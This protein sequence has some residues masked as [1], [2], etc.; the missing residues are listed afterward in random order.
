MGSLLGLG[1]GKGDG[2]ELGVN[3]AFVLRP[4]RTVRH[5]RLRGMAVLWVQ[6]ALSL[7]P[8]TREEC[9]AGYVALPGSSHLKTFTEG[10]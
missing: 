5:P 7:G 4:R 6:D 9:R 8:G 3:L 1:E 10:S 2:Q